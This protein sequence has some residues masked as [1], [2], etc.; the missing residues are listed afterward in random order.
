[1]NW[2]LFDFLGVVKSWLKALFTL[3]GIV[4]CIFILSAI[5]L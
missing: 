5:Y 4:S 2:I 3:V 1:M